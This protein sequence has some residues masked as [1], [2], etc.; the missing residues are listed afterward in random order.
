MRSLVRCLSMLGLALLFSSVA[1]AE[2]KN[3]A[4]K[5]A[6]KKAEKKAL[7]SVDQAF[8]LPKEIKL[9]EDQQKKIDELKKEYAPKFEEL[10]K[11]LDAIETPER[12]KSAGEAGKKSKEDGKSKQEIQEAREAAMKLS[13]A[14]KSQLKELRA[15]SAALRKETRTKKAALLTDEQKALLKPKPKEKKASSK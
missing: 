12:R 2:D 11:K 13:D 7:S 10:K 15:A 6:E 1:P 9:S 3:P 4:D 8:A 14:E 5:K